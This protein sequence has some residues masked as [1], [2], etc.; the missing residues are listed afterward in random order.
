MEKDL[1]II[2]PAY[3]PEFLQRALESICKQTNQNFQVYIGNDGSPFDLAKICLPYCQK[4]GWEYHEFGSNLGKTNLVGHW[5]RCVRMSNSEKWIWLFSDDDEMQADC[6][7][8]FYLSLKKH[9]DTRVF[10]FDFSIIDEHS[11]V[12]RSNDESFPSLTAFEFGK[13]RFERKIFSSA[14][15]FIFLRQSFDAANGFV[16]FPSAWCSDDA[17]WIKFTSDA[18]IISI[19]GGRVYWRMS[20]FNI[21]GGKKEYKNDKL[22]AA[23]AFIIWFNEKFPHSKECTVFGDQIIWLRIQMMQNSIILSFPVVLDVIRIIKPLKL[24]HQLCMFN[25]LY[26]RNQIIQEKESGKTPTSIMVFFARTFPRF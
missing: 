10:R 18:P 8:H 4:Y 12:T 11:N 14:V 6:V 15:E 19:K 3:K 9:P 5:N 24:I 22:N 21:S 26:F 7:E 20:S 13:L 25:E 16:N 17:S 2:I 23:I 1:A